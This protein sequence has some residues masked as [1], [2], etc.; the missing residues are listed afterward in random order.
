LP[1]CALTTNTK[2]LSKIGHYLAVGFIKYLP[3]RK[4]SSQFIPCTDIPLW[5]HFSEIK[6]NFSLGLM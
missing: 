6:N 5:K 1:L 4:A 3:Y 2:L